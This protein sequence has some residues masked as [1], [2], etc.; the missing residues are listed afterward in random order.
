MNEPTMI[1]L[2][3]QISS[4]T[5]S[6][7]KHFS[8]FRDPNVR[9][10]R[11]SAARVARI[12]QLLHKALHETDNVF[13]EMN[14]RHNGTVFMRLRVPRLSVIWDTVLEPYEFEFLRRDVGLRSVLD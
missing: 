10:A 6:R 12:G 4:G 13:C 7:N 1:D 3:S 9:E 5:L 11:R 2:M 8:A 14:Q